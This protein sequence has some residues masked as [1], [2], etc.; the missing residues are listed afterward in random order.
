MVLTAQE[1]FERPE[2]IPVDGRVAAE[3]EHPTVPVDD[4]SAPVYRRIVESQAEQFLRFRAWLARRSMLRPE[5]IDT[6]ALLEDVRAT[7]EESGT[8]P[9]SLFGEGLVGHHYEVRAVVADREG[10][11]VD[12]TVGRSIG[13]GDFHGY[14]LWV[15]ED[16]EG[17]FERTGGGSANPDPVIVGVGAALAGVGAGAAGYRVLGVDGE[18]DDGGGRSDGQ[19]DDRGELG[20]E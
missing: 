5:R 3:I 13:A 16:G 20:E 15:P 10:S 18:A 14:R 19:P 2:S 9:V 4:P 11:I 6:A 8:A 7:V 12:A 1:Y 17:T